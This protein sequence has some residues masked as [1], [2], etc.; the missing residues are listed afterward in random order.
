M[1][2]LLSHITILSLAIMLTA[3][4]S[5]RVSQDYLKFTDFNSLKTYRWDSD[6]VQQ[7]NRITNNNPL[8]NQRIH[9]AIDNKLISMGYRRVDEVADFIISYQNAVEARLSSDGT[10]GVFSIGFGNIGR[11]GALGISSGNEIKEQDEA[12]LM[13]DIISANSEKLLWRGISTREVSA[14]NDPDEL[15]ETINNHVNAIL[16]QFP[17]Y[18]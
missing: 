13:I 9:T 11:F 7:E 18:K 17:P 4:A 14:H 16:N 1:Y 2:K 10:A 8:L 3:C 12:T 6:F 5:I 15:T